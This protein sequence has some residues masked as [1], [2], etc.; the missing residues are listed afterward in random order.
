VSAPAPPPTRRGPLVV[1]AIAAIAAVTIAAIVLLPRADETPVAPSPSPTGSDASPTSAPTASSTAT[2]AASPSATATVGRYVSAELG[3][4]MDIAAPWHRADCGSFTLRDFG[5]GERD[6]RDEFIP[7]PESDYRPSGTGSAVDTV[8]VFVRAN[9]QRLTP[10]AWEQAG[11][12]G[13]STGRVL[14][15]VTFAGRPALRAGGSAEFE[16]FL[17]ANDEFMFEVG[18][19]GN[20]AQTTA[21]SRGAIVRTFRFLTADELRAAR[22]ALTTAP[23]PP[24]SPEQ[25]ADVLADG[26][27][28]RD[29]TVL[30][31]VLTPDCVSLGLAQS[32]GTGVDDATYLE[33]LRMRFAR[34]LMVTAQ[35]RPL[36]GERTGSLPTLHARSTWREPGQPDQDIDLMISPEGATWYWRGNVVYPAG[37]RP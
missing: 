35:P 15:D 6:A 19:A 7:I 1:V 8:H 33:E 22:A 2:A 27:A 30:R 11:K 13:F 26:F 25:V 34:G 16:L 4:A 18:H 32:G 24:R 14:E 23:S 21:A 31:S 17:V 36:T 5:G 12:I 9:P 29:V 3:Y 37:R 20:G 28:R 10:R